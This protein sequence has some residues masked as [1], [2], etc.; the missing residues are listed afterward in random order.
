M[1]E[2]DGLLQ[3]SVE[4]FT[5]GTVYRCV[6][7]NKKPKQ[8]EG[9]P[10]TGRWE[11][12]LTSRLKETGRGRVVLEPRGAQ[13]PDAPPQPLPRDAEAIKPGSAHCSQ[14]KSTCHLFGKDSLFRHNH[15][16]LSTYHLWPLSSYNGGVEEALQSLCGPLQGKLATPVTEA[17]GLANIWERQGGMP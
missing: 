2:L 7:G 4:E 15:A 10:G 3:H 5:G 1:Q 17:Q 12:V 8:L 16:I 13:E 14:V 11:T 6:G 9:L